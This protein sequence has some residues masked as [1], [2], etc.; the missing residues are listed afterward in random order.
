MCTR[1]L[2]TRNF[3]PARHPDGDPVFSTFT[4]GADAAENTNTTYTISAGDTFNGTIG[5][6][7]DE[8]WIRISLTEGE[9]YTI[10]MDGVTLYDPLVRIYD[11]TG[12]TVLGSNDDANS[13]LFSELVFT[14]DSTGTYYIEA[15]TYDYGGAG[16]FYEIGTYTLN[17]TEGD[18]PKPPDSGDAASLDELALFL[19]E[20]FWGG[21][22]ITFDT[23]S[24]NQITVNLDGLTSAAKQLARWAMDSWDCLLYTSPSPRDRTRS[25]MPSSA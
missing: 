21:S 14:A 15:D 18:T 23:S 10:T 12:T 3:D 11:A 25:R 7:S 13:S 9:T 2:L 24:S 16:D 4:E 17:V 8:D 6:S 20:G 22:E 5:S 19:T 1:C